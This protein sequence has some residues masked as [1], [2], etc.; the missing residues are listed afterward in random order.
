MDSD[1]VVLMRTHAYTNT[2]LG[3]VFNYFIRDYTN[4]PSV[5]DLFKV[6]DILISDYSA[7]M[8]DYSILERPI[9]ALAM[10]MIAMP[11]QEDCMLIWKACCQ[12]VYREQK[13]R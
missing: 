10:I 5:N 4:Y 6:A 2:L 12:M 13:T 3:I 8:A 1:Y 9:I 11:R 7:A